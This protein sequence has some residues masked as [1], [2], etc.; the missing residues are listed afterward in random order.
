MVVVPVNGK[1]RF[2]ADGYSVD[3]PEFPALRYSF[4]TEV[5]EQARRD[6]RQYWRN[7]RFKQKKAEKAAAEAESK[8][9]ETGGR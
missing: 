8:P 5:A 6:S 1:A 7:Y 9:D 4:F 2:G 3:K